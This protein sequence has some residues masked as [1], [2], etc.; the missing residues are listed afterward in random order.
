TG[1][2]AQQ[3][4]VFK[5]VDLSEKDG[6]TILELRRAAPNAAEWAPVGGGRGG[7]GG[8]AMGGGMRQG[9]GGTSGNNFLEGLVDSP[10][11]DLRIT[12][13]AGG[14]ILTPNSMQSDG[15][16]ITLRFQGPKDQVQAV[17]FGSRPYE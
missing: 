14:R 4:E 10:D 2:A 7:G 13:R 16:A 17:L 12:L 8:G 5:F 15:Q 6:Q 1:A 9:G 3:P 11:F